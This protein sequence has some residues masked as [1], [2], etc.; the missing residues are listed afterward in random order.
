MKIT[1]IITMI[2]VA[3]ACCAMLPRTMIARGETVPPPFGA[4]KGNIGNWLGDGPIFGFDD[5]IGD[6]E[7]G[8]GPGGGWGGGWW[9]GGSGGGGNGSGGSGGREYGGGG[10]DEDD[11]PDFGAECQREGIVTGGPAP[12]EDVCHCTV[13]WYGNEKPPT[14]TLTGGICRLLEP[15]QA[16]SS[17]CSQVGYGCLAWMLW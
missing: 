5:P 8:G 13:Y 9:E 2:G 12:C 6:G 1:R 17:Q 7:L 4:G 11:D 10:G 3:L 16:P 15:D 14:G